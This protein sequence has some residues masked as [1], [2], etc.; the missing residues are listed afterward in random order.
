[1]FRVPNLRALRRVALVLPFCLLMALPV[2]A[3]DT[4]CW[5][6][7]YGRGVGE[8]L[9]ECGSDQE[10]SGLLCYPGCDAGFEGVGPV[11]WSQCQDGYVDD[12]ATCRLPADIIAKESYG[13]GAGQPM[14]CAEGLVYEAGL[15]YSQCEQG[16]RGDVTAC[17]QDC[18]AGYSDS[19]SY[20]GKPESYGRGAGYALWDKGIC[21]RDHGVGNCETSG[22]LIYPKCKENFHAAGCCVCSPDCPAGWEDIGVSCKKPVRNRGVGVAINSCPAGMEKDGALCYPACNDGYT[23]VGPVCWSQ[24]PA[25]YQDDGG[26]CRKDSI[27]VAKESRGRGVGEP[28]ICGGGLEESAAL[29]YTPCGEGS[30]GIGPV[31]WGQCPSSMPV[32]CGAACAVSEDACI[33]SVRLMLIQGAKMAIDVVTFGGTTAADVNDAMDDA[34]QAL[35]KGVSDAA[36]DAGTGAGGRLG[37]TLGGAAVT[38]ATSTAISGVTAAGVRAA[39]KASLQQFLLP[40]SDIVDFANMGI[41]ADAATWSSMIAEAAQRAPGGELTGGHLLALMS[42]QMSPEEHEALIN[43]MAVA[44]VDENTTDPYDILAAIPL[45]NPFG[46][47]DFVDTFRKGSCSEYPDNRPSGS[48]PGGLVS[49]LNEGAIGMPV[50]DPDLFSTPTSYEY[51]TLGVLLTGD[52]KSDGSGL[53]V[54]KTAKQDVDQ[55][56]IETLLEG[57]IDPEVAAAIA[58]R[59]ESGQLFTPGTVEVRSSREDQA[60]SAT[61]NRSGNAGS[62]LNPQD[63]NGTN[64][65]EVTFDG[66]LFRQTSAGA[67][68][69]VDPAGTTLARYNETGRDEWSVYLRNEDGQYDV[70]IDLWKK[71]I[72]R[73]PVGQQREV[74]A[75]V[76]G[77]WRRE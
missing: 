10:K 50:Y 59:F 37:Q 53:A 43:Q 66:G 31:C 52:A 57:N 46:I 33:Q 30:D 25:G 35:A 13:R 39:L 71:T 7:N 2:I 38:S 11:C 24:C 14:V 62:S 49:A 42:L 32:E 61:M 36:K 41:Y 27:I 45:T 68:E 4:F 77:S 55:D 8:P 23:G 19:G 58:A 65:V 29:C 63:V 64:A 60:G 1:M 40:F 5:R 74:M 72:S 6:D 9:S 70:Q 22:A 15:C 3:Q 76:T 17:Y 44:F 21:E 67:W 56:M 16:W 26:T 12:G 51:A 20:C 69:S 75:E 34:A 47:L 18:P 48:T 28:M 54:M 73:G